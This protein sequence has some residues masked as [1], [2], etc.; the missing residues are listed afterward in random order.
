MVLYPQDSSQ[1]ETLS[2]WVTPDYARW[3]YRKTPARS[4]SPCRACQS[5]MPHTHGMWRIWVPTVHPGALPGVTMHRRAS[6]APGSTSPS[7]DSRPC[8]SGG[9]WGSTEEGVLWRILCHP[10]KTLPGTPVVTDRNSAPCRDGMNTFKHV[11]Y[12]CHREVILIKKATFTMNTEPSI[13]YLQRIKK[14]LKARLILK[15]E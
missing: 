10:Y 11:L 5:A 12:T 3:G 2:L 15:L 9:A 8:P 1:M 6:E 14:M 13:I 7:L 4:T